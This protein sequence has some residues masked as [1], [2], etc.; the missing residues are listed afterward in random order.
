VLASLHAGGSA[1]A[2]RVATDDDVLLVATMLAELDKMF[3]SKASA[4][5]VKSRV[6]NW[7]ADPYISGVYSTNEYGIERMKKPECNERIC[8]CGEYLADGD[9]LQV[10]VHGAAMSGREVAQEVLL[11]AART[12]AF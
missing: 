12:M 7:S 10:M 4:H 3:D 2:E 9:E 1:T 8:L 5:Y 6:K 11:N